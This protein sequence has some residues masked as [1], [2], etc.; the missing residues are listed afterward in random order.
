VLG[1]DNAFGKTTP[2]GSQNA[3]TPPNQTSPRPSLQISAVLM[4]GLAPLTAM[5]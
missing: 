5:W 1:A 2:N 3:Y 4:A